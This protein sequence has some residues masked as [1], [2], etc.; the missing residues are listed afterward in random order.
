M[1]NKPQ[2]TFQVGQTVWMLKWVP[3]TKTV[4]TGCVERVFTS[5]GLVYYAFA[6]DPEDVY[7]AC[8]LYSTESEAKVALLE[9]ALALAQVRKNRAEA[10]LEHARAALAEAR[11]SVGKAAQ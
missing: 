4:A 11:A 5:D 9:Y 10:E 8:D 7:A 1:T 2:Q 6:D 3:G